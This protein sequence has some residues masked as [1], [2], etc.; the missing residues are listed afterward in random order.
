MNRCPEC[1][2]KVRE[3]TDRETDRVNG[4]FY[5]KGCDRYCSPS[6]YGTHMKG[7]YEEDAFPKEFKKESK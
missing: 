3:I 6:M 5:C 1:N 7:I 2:C 4:I